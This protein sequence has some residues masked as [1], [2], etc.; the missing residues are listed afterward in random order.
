MEYTHFNDDADEP[1][2]LYRCDDL[3]MMNGL[4]FYRGEGQKGEDVYFR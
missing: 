4:G 3:P 1:A 2:Y